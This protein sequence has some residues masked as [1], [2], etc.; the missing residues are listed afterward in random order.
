MPTTSIYSFTKESL[1]Q[2]RLAANLPEYSSW[3][4]TDQLYRMS[5]AFFYVPRGI[6]HLLQRGFAH[7]YVYPERWQSASVGLFNHH[8]ISGDI[9]GSGIYR[10]PCHPYHL[11]VLSFIFEYIRVLIFAIADHISIVVAVDLR[12]A[13]SL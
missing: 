4:A 7:E 6:A 9:L 12:P 8:L 1:R 5:A 11:V 3:F 2:S 10:A 13:S